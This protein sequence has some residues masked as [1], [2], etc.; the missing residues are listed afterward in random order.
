MGAYLSTT[1]EF[2]NETELKLQTA[3]KDVIVTSLDIVKYSNKI[4]RLEI[5]NKL[6]DSE[7]NFLNRK[8]LNHINTV[9]LEHA[10]NRIMEL[11]QMNE[12][13]QQKLKNTTTELTNLYARLEHTEDKIE[14]LNGTKGVKNAKT[15][16]R[17]ER[18]LRF[19]LKEAL[20]RIEYQPDSCV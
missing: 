12:K 9:Q 4:N 7:I 18:A 11:E 2:P 20:Q 19:K 15:A 1:E 5:S 3:N 13:L 16:K 6:K 8:L 17:R 10:E 14:E